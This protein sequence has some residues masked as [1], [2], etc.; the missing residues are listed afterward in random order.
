VTEDQPPATTDGA[1][2]VPLDGVRPEDA[3]VIHSMRDVLQVH[4]N[5][6]HWWN[7]ASFA[8]PLLGFVG[9]VGI[10]LLADSAEALGFGLFLGVIAVLML[11]VV[12][13]TWRGTAT[14]IVLT[15]TGAAALHSGRVMREVAWDGLEAIE[16]VETMGNVRWKLRPREGEHLTVEG[17]LAN[18]AAL[19]DRAAGLSG[20]TPRR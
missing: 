10:G 18:V 1:V 4:P 8:L 2:D 13:Y 17:E 9:L 12:Y 20:V 19:I 14:A 11:P 6:S 3:A 5:T 15:R 16:R 7:H